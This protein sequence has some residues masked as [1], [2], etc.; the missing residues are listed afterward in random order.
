MAVWSLARIWTT[1]YNHW[2]TWITRHW[3]TR[4]LLI[5]TLSLCSQQTWKYWFSL[6]ADQKHL[7]LIVDTMIANNIKL[8]AFVLCIPTHVLRITPSLAKTFKI[9]KSVFGEEFHKN[10][11]IE[12]TWTKHDED[13]YYERELTG[14]VCE[15]YTWNELRCIIGIALLISLLNDLSRKVNIEN[16]FFGNYNNI[17]SF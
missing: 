1:H 15:N 14:N 12:F 7:N 11:V 13:S 2:H 9:F 8:N 4:G 17:W 3:R 10:L 16:F 5:A 6:K